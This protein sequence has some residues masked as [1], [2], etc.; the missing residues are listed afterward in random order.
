MKK[1]FLLYLLLLSCIINLNALDV[2]LSYA[3]FQS[4]EQPYIEIY[5]HMVGSTVNFKAL[6]DST[7][8]A[9]IEVL[10]LFKKGEEIVQYDKF[11]LNSPLTQGPAIDFIDIKRYGLL[12]GT[13][14]LIAAIKDLNQPENAKEYATEIIIDYG[15][16]ELQ[17]SGIQLLASYTKGKPGDPFLKNGLHL[18]PL[19]YNYY[20][21]S[22]SNLSF[23]TEIYN[24]D[25]AVGE[26]FM[27]SYMIEKME[28]GKGQ[29]VMIGHKRKEAEALIPLLIQMDIT[30]LASGNYRLVVETR[31]R[32][33]EKLS[34]KSIFFQRSNPFLRME[35][36][37]LASVNIK[38]EFVEQLKP[39]E[40]E[41]SLRA[42]TPKIPQ[43][44]IE[45]VNYMLKKDSVEGQRLYLFSY[46]AKASPNNPQVA[47]DKY[48]EVARAIDNQFQ[49]GFRHGFETDR[50]YVYLKYGQPDDI[51]RRETEP[52]APPYEV[53]SY[54]DFPATNQT[55]VRFIF[56][57]P[58]LAPE[59]FE[60]LHSNAIGELNNPQ[61][62]HELYRDAPNQIEGTDYFGG[63]QVQDN[64]NRDANRVFRD[65]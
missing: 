9:S 47:Y 27:V 55:N 22:A 2:S 42:L 5:L 15:N 10:Y 4:N 63:T 19:P 54:N 62:Q 64:F 18:E 26:D 29:T 39:E 37:D 8:Q 20:G 43:T 56:Y 23:Y 45:M 6:N 46:W 32:L 44:D 59:D 38:E 58:S 49:C 57:N 51:E 25:K 1:P 16:T 31:N 30:K 61:W 48:M 24:A 65:Y 34:Q 60:L 3:T 35:E 28:N 21:R 11:N 53:W 41:Y 52:S 36:L 14:Q 50:G 17:Q 12:N 13:Y 40:L 33:K 7:S